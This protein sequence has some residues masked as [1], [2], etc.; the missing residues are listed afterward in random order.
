MAMPALATGP[1]DDRDAIASFTAGFSLEATRP[2][3]ADIEAL[4][5]SAP[6][7]TAVYLSAIPARPLAELVEAAR[8]V[9]TAGFGS[10]RGAA[11]LE[12]PTV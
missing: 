5:A 9:R 3:P 7:G 4:K 10:F 8:L 6:A 1:D 11:K 2:K 12:Q